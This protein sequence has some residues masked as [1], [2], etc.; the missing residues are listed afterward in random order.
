MFAKTRERFQ[1]ATFWTS[2]RNFVP[3]LLS[4][5]EEQSS[6]KAKPDPEKEWAGLSRYTQD[7]ASY[8][9][10]EY[11]RVTEI[12]KSPVLTLDYYYDSP[13]FVTQES[14]TAELPDNFKD[15]NGD[16]APEYGL[17]MIIEG[18]TVNYGPWADRHRYQLQ[19]MFFPRL[20]K[21]AL[22]SKR[23]RVGQTR[24]FTQFNIYVEITQKT[25]LQIPTKE[26]SKDW[27]YKGSM[28]KR[29]LP[30]SLELTV[31]SNST[32]SYSMGMVPLREKWVNKLNVD[33]KYPELRTSVNHGLLFKADV[34]KV[35]GDLSNPLVWNAFHKWTFE[36]ISQDIKLFLLREHIILLT[37]LIGDWT[38]GP[39]A[40]HATFVPFQYSIKLQFLNIELPLNV[41][42][43]NIIDDP[44]DYNNNLFLIGKTRELQA[45]F[46]IPL[47]RFR[48]AF[49]SIPFKI[50]VTEA[51]LDL[52]MPRWNT[53]FSFIDTNE[54]AV[55]RNVMLSGEYHYASGTGPDLVDTL[56]LDANGKY[57]L[58]RLDGY[59]IRYFLTLQKN[60][61]G[62]NLHFK[63]FNEHHSTAQRV[64]TAETL[65][66]PVP[67]SDHQVHATKSNDIDVLLTVGFSNN[68]ILLPSNIYSAKSH[69]A[70]EVPDIAIDMRFTNYYMGKWYIFSSRLLTL[71][72]CRSAS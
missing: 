45:S 71:T 50:S 21:N 11:A 18:G 12:L 24:V 4:D 14:T 40:D 36:S 59:L 55:V 68:N 29:R 61:F 23:I 10:G 48:P 17:D 62:E 37:D 2:I 57:L 38:S 30:G 44:S 46:E 63:T 54:I 69:V 43:G 32:I 7:D 47:E 64:K 3:D 22:P 67:V 8:V 34:Q 33:L 28:D 25:V 15:I 60:Y 39:P 72:T 51:V 35:T 20:Y 66:T 42:D 41:N 52:H 26:F 13:G 49:N 70:L 6:E 9:D 16:S 56:T 58:L 53:R 5:K 65:D 19:S 27:K 31:L 1:F